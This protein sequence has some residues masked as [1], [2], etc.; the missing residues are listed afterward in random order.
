MLTIVLTTYPSWNSNSFVMEYGAK[1]TTLKLLISRAHRRMESIVRIS[2]DSISQL[3]LYK[4]TWVDQS[5][6]KRLENGL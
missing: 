1:Y 2:I 5:S 4:A 6:W 3:V